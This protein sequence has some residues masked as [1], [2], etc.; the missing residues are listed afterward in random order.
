MLCDTYG[1]IKI[2]ETDE[3]LV[4]PGTRAGALKAAET[5][6][7]KDEAYIKQYG[8]GFYQYIGMKGGKLS[9]TGGFYQNRELARRAGA[10]GGRIS[11]RKR[12]ET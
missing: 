4:M 1:R 6:K 9:R 11:K 10:I 7:K 8:V 12:R 2:N 5:N 3:E